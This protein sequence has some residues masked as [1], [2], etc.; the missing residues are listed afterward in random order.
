MNVGQESKQIDL[1]REPAFQLGSADV[2]PSTRQFLVGDAREVLEP[3]VMQG[4][5]ALARRRGEGVTR[6]ELTESC[7]SGRVVGDDAVSRCIAAVR[8]LASTYG[9]FSLETIPRVGYRLIEETPAGQPPDR[10]RVPATL[11]AWIGRHWKAVSAAAVVLVLASSLLVPMLWPH[12]SV[13]P[14]PPRLT[15]A[16]LPFTPLYAGAD[17]QQLGDAIAVSIADVLTGSAWDVVSTTKSLQYRGVAKAGAAQALHADF[18]IDGDIRR[19]AGTAVV[20]LRV[21]EGSTGKTLVAGS[22]ERP[23]AEAANLPDDVATQL[24]QMGTASRGSKRPAGWDAR[25]MAGYFRA[26]FQYGGRND[27]YGANE[28]ARSVAKIAPDDAFAQSL[29]GFT[30]AYLAAALPP[31]RRPAMIAEARQAAER[32][33]LL[34][35]GYGDSYAVLA[36]TT[37]LFDWAARE[38]HLK[39]GLAAFPESLAVQIQL[40]ELFQNAG[41]FRDSAP[42]AEAAFRYTPYQTRALIELT[43][44]RLW[45]GDTDGSRVLIDRGRQLYPRSPWFV[46]KMFEATAFRGAPADAQALLR[47]AAVVKLLMPDGTLKTFGAVEAALSR[48]RPSDIRAV[49]EDCRRSEGRTAEVK[50]TCFM[51]LVA[52]RRLDDAFALAAALYPDQRAATADARQRR[53][54]STEV[55]ATAYLSVPVTAPLRADPRYR[56]LVERIGLL[57]YWQSSHRAPDFCA[58][59]KAPVCRL[60]D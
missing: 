16:V 57:Q 42:L 7:W 3:R 14:N 35:P 48:R 44:A 34:D 56:E 26:T 24:A 50:R 60:L 49:V 25:V 13:R 39:S 20:A 8:R 11:L 33:I 19:E 17:G 58:L 9:G 41:R 53:W 28:T 18:L 37:P 40:V 6:E 30:A 47:D 12:P 29:H 27:L 10:A 59:E 51:A 32:A 2:R 38:K 52:L 45:L 31:E 46:A 23:V 54:L 43:N 4:L 55:S 5:V 15:I 22:I 36:L 21:I 1:A